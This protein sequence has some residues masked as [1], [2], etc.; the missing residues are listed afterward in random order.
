MPEN[1]NRN[2]DLVFSNRVHKLDKFLT[3]NDCTKVPAFKPCYETTRLLLIGTTKEL[4]K[5]N[6]DIVVLNQVIDKLMG[7]IN[8]I[9]DNLNDK[10][11]K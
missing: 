4:D 5:A 3:N 6:A 8:A 10:K 1:L 9:I 2:K 7:N 11:E